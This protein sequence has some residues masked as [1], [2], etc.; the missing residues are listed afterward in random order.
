MVSKFQWKPFWLATQR[1]PQTD[2][3]ATQN[4][5]NYDVFAQAPSVG[6]N[7]QLFVFGIFTKFQRR[8]PSR[9]LLGEIK[10]KRG[11]SFLNVCISERSRIGDPLE[12]MSPSFRLVDAADIQGGKNCWPLVMPCQRQTSLALGLVWDSWHWLRLEL[13]T[14]NNGFICTARLTEVRMQKE[15][16]MNFKRTTFNTQKKIFSS[17]INFFCLGHGGLYRNHRHIII[18]IIIIYLL[19]PLAR[20]CGGYC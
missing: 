17:F 7:L 10:V 20:K 9:V 13:A 3:T 1:D 16:R 5:V 12:T 4:R 19:H 8:Q 18:I 11:V 2:W 14:E 6:G 15:S